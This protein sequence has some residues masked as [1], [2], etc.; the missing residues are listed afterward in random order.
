MG[1]AMKLS[2]HFVLVAS[3]V[4]MALSLPGCGNDGSSASSGIRQIVSTTSFGMCVG[5]CSTR[6]EISEGKAVLVRSARGGRGTSD[7]PDQRFEA[8]LTESE[9]REIARLA[10]NTNLDG[11]PPVIG[12]PDCAVGGAES[13]IIEG[14][15]GAEEIKFDHGATIEPAQPLLERVRA[16]RTKLTPTSAE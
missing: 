11:L 12:C 1:E 14:P 6:L 2:R 7:L 16:L 10:E 9:W 8:T 13:L 15:G 5:Y 3:V 4:A